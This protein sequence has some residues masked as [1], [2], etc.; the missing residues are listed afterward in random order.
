MIHLKNIGL[1]CLRM[2]TAEPGRSAVS[3][4]PCPLELGGI[5]VMLV[6][7]FVELGAVALGN[8]RRMTDITVGNLQQ[9]GKVFAFEA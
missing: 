8:T 2:E 7:Q 9:L 4:R 3:G 1:D 5:Q 6:Q